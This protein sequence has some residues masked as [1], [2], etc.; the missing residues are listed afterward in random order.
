ML[1]PLEPAV[2][3]FKI[4]RSMRASAS[5]RLRR[6][7]SAS[8]SVTGRRVSPSPVSRPCRARNIQFAS[9]LSDITSRL[10]ASGIVSSCSRTSRTAC[11]RNSFVYVCRGNR[12]IL[13]LQFP[14]SR[15]KA[16]TFSS[17]A[18]ESVVMSEIII[19]AALV[20]IL[21]NFLK[22]WEFVTPRLRAYKKILI[23]RTLTSLRYR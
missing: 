21:A 4:S 16:S 19:L 14:Y 10:A 22:V 2:A 13:H 23:C 18:H 5:S 8:R 15:L 3:F 11:S 12:S 17:L 6:D 20:S 1:S 7:T 9:V